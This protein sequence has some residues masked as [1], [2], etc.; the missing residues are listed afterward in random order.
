MY[1][2][3]RILQP[4]MPSSAL[5]F[6]SHLQ[7]SHNFTRN[8]FQTVIDNDEV[9]VIWGSEQM[10]NNLRN[11]SDIQFDATFKYVP[12]LFYQL[13]TIFINFKD[14]TLPALHVLMT[15]KTERLYTVVLLTIRQLIPG[16]N[17]TFAIGDFKQASRNAFIAVFPSITIIS[18]WFHFT[19]AIFERVQKLDLS[20]LYQ[21]NQ[22]FSM[23]IRKIMA[24]PL[25]PEKEEIRSVYLSLEIPSIGIDDAE[26]ELI[27]KFRS[28]FHRTWIIGHE[29]LSVFIYENATNNGAESYHKNLKAIIK[30]P[31]PNIWKF[32]ACLE[33]VIADYDIEY[34][35]LFQGFETTRGS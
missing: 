6:G 35:R 7:E 32:T 25:L 19:K 33:N 27:K 5:E 2:R 22:S 13:F 12:K 9:A 20:K 24:L 28:Y 16:F 23:W 1:K 29:N 8:H 26:K 21:R 10:I 4:K 17:P 34:Q 11:S 30:T 3:R 15:R 18:C 14:H 31:H